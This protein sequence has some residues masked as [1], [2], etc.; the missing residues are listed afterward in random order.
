MNDVDV[1]DGYWACLCCGRG[2]PRRASPWCVTCGALEY[3]LLGF[4]RRTGGYCPPASGHDVDPRMLF[5]MRTILM[6]CH[7]VMGRRIKEL[8]GIPDTMMASDV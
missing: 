7:P 2:T 8:L 4:T 6:L 1:D 5:T 3:Q